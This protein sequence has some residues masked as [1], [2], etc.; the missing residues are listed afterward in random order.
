[1]LKGMTAPL[2]KDA[3][4]TYGVILGRATAAQSLT[5][6]TALQNATSLSF[7]IAASEEW[8][9]DFCLDI[10]AL[11]ATTGLKIAVNAPA[12]ATL[13]LTVGLHASIVTALNVLSGR[14]T[15]IATAIDFTAAT[16]AAMTSSTVHGQLWVLNSTTAGTM[17]LQFAQS[18]SSASALTIQKGSFL[19][20]FRVA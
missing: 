16:L 14:T 8:V 1:M 2:I 19:R 13:N 11:L 9:A 7:A 18:T 6:Q 17:Q 15:A 3:A 20:A 4:A 5:T 12:G 10:G